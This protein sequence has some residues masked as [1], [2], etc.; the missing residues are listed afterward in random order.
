MGDFAVK[1]TDYRKIEG[2]DIDHPEVKDVNMRVVIGE[3][4]GAPNFVMRVFTV[5]PGGHT[6]W[7]THPYEHELFF[8]AGSGAVRYGDNAETDIT[9]VGPGTV[10]YVA[11]DEIHQIRNTGTEDLVFVC[12]I[13]KG[14]V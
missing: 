3:D 7:H 8:H 1:C 4:D 9:P 11:P 13:P 12:L 10:A 14:V 6:P 5:K 2:K